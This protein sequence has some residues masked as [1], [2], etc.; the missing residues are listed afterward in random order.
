MLEI[1]EADEGLFVALLL[2]LRQYIPVL[3]AIDQAVFFFT[4]NAEVAVLVGVEQEF[5]K[6]ISGLIKQL[7]VSLDAKNGSPANNGSASA[8]RVAS[9][10]W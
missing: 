4:G 2:F 7:L 10:P 8:A 6:G 3:T 1:I 9:W 5:G